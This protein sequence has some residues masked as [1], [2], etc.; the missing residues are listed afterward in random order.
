MGTSSFVGRIDHQVK[1][2][3]F[4]IELGEVEAVLG[5][6]PSVAA[7]T[8]IVREHGNGDK[9]LVAYLAA[10]SSGGGASPPDCGSSFAGSFLTTWC[11]RLLC[12]SKS[13]R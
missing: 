12:F 7:A 8:V 2:R 10:G 6:H 4:R 13:C 11:L 5:Q 9:Q 3:G 1:I